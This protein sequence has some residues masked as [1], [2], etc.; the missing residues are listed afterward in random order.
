MGI[1][2]APDNPDVIYVANTTSWKSTDG[3]KTFFGFKGAPG[4]DDYQH[5]W[6]STENPQIMALSADQGAAISVNGGATWS[7]WYN[8]PT[9]QFYDVTTDNRFPYWVYGGQQ[10]SGSVATRS[11]SDYGEISYRDWSLPGV[12][13]YGRIAVD[14]VDPNILY[15]GRITRTNQALGEV[16][17][18]SPEPIRR[19]EYRYD[20]TLPMVF[21]PFDPKMLYFGANVVFK[22]TDQG[23]SWSIISPDLTRESYDAPANLGAFSA[24]DPEKGKHRGTIYAL[25]PSFKEPDTIWAGTDDGLIQLTRD[26][27]KTWKNVTPPQLKPWSKVSMIGGFAFRCGH[28]VCRHQQLPPGRSAPAHLPHADFG[29]TWQEITAGMAENAPSNVVREDPARKGLL[30]AGT[31]TCV[32]VS[33]NEGDS[34]QPAAVEPAAHFDAR[35]GNPWRRSGGGHAWPVVLDPG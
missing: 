15:G 24:G 4:G 7:T 18:V 35:P 26:G 30:F 25:A 33:F 31:E 19:G 9:A 21:S 10:E 2:V 20:R 1:A 5:I 29:A 32:Y 23:R 34:W 28:C 17:D 22:T 14:P 8:Q 27:G 12:Q 13:E 3:G 6:I 11:R 16:A